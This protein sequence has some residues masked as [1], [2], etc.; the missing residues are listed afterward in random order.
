MSD[1][2]GA[3]YQPLVEPGQASQEQEVVQ[4]KYVTEDAL[5]L[6][7]EKATKEISKRI[8]QSLE[9]QGLALVD[10]KLTK[11][12]DVLKAQG[13]AVT[14]DMLNQK[15]IQLAT[16]EADRALS[17]DRPAQEDYPQVDPEKVREVRAKMVKLQAQLEVFPDGTEKEFENFNWQDPDP[18]RF[19]QGYEARLKKLA[20]RQG[21]AP[22][23]RTLD[24]NP[25]ARVP[26]PAGVQGGDRDA[27][28]SNRLQQIQTQ[29]PY[30]RDPTLS[31]ERS[32]IM[33]ELEV[34]HRNRR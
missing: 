24:G 9:D 1:D 11:W 25:T 5:K 30:K 21:A 15:R 13:I 26:G 10:K 27:Q 7:L 32:E 31:K 17:D 29:D 4:P 2:N 16:A 19:F 3:E 28:L 33:K 14:D 12:A 22:E 18:D 6:A 20:D 8:T 23:P 34:L